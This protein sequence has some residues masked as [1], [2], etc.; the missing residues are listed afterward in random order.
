MK[1]KI[2]D[3]KKWLEIGK[4]ICFIHPVVIA[5]LVPATVVLLCYS[6]GYSEANPI[7]AYFSYGFS[8]YTL[9]TVAVRMP[10][11]IKRI[12]KG[13]Y[14]NRYSRTYLTDRQVRYMIS[15]H[16]GLGINI[17]YAVL[18]FLAGFYFKSMWLGAVAVYYMVLSLIR[19]GLLRKERYSKRYECD[20]EKRLYGLKAYRFC[21][22]LMFLLNIAVSVL[23]VQMIWQNKFYSYPGFLIFA[24]AAYSFYCFITA[25]INM[26]KY[27]K[28]EQP[29][30]SAAKMI[31]FACAIM[32]I[33]TMQTGMLTQFSTSGQENFVRLM[34]TFTGGAVCLIIFLMAVLM[35]KRGNT[36]IRKMK[37]NIN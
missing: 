21:G 13:L 19:F 1:G 30:F 26:V 10:A 6:L 5:I 3:W 23:V 35:V 20:E 25:I 12:R 17:L 37:N 32:S 28:M 31:S 29:I 22:Y 15:L 18:K 16:T 11:L 36:E 9:V 2:T 14:S 34:N 27:R 4:K 24:S 8:A 7:I 33:L